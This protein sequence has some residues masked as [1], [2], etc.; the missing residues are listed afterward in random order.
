MDFQ[1]KAGAAEADSD[2]NL[3][4]P[5]EWAVALM[6]SVT[7]LSTAFAEQFANLEHQQDSRSALMTERCESANPKIHC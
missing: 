3:G 5:P 1:G 6:N 4:Q 7:H 2:R